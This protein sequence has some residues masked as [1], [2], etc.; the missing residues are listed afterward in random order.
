MDHHFVVYKVDAVYTFFVISGFL[1]T[2][3]I[4]INLNEYVFSWMVLVKF[5]V[6]EMYTLYFLPFKR[7]FALYRVY[8]NA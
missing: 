2:R 7:T 3:S 8:Q 5:V 1:A 6:H 4:K